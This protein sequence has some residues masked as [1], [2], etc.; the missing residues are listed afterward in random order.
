MTLSTGVGAL[1]SFSR[2]QRAQGVVCLH[3]PSSTWLAATS[4]TALQFCG[5]AGKA[6]NQR[7]GHLESLRKGLYNAETTSV[8]AG[9]SFIK[10]E[11]VYRLSVPIRLILSPSCAFCSMAHPRFKQQ[12][13]PTAW[14]HL[15]MSR[16]FFLAFA[17][18]YLKQW[19]QW[20]SL[21]GLH[22]HQQMLY[23]RKHLRVWCTL[24]CRSVGS[25]ACRSNSRSEVNDHGLPCTFNFSALCR[26]GKC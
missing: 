21:L 18:R 15:L 4:L 23:L 8:Q 25:L 20:H 1:L 12:Q 13:L 19:C 9:Y 26:G 10:K 11:E 7:L 6:R 5:T 14:V 22:Q 16:C 24:S 17:G 2:C 3:S